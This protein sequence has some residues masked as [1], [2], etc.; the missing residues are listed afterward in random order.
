VVPGSLFI[1]RRGKQ[2]DGN[3][4]VPEAISSGAACVLS[5]VYDPSIS[6]VTQLLTDDVAAIE[7]RI[8]AAFWQHPSRDLHMIG[9]TG[10]SGKTTVSYIVHHLFA[11]FGIEAGLIGSVA[12]VSGVKSIAAS[13]TTP[14]A[15]TVQRLLRE[16]V[17]EGM[18]ASVMEVSSHGLSQRRVEGVEFDT[19]VFTNLSHEHLD[20]HMNMK[21]YAR[22]KRRL[23]T[24][25]QRTECKDPVIIVNNQDSWAEFI[26]EGSTGR[27]FTYAVEGEADLVASS[28]QLRNDGSSFTFRFQGEE[29]FVRSP[30]LGRFNV[31]NFLAA[32]GVFLSR[33]YALEEVA[34]GLATAAAPPG[35]LERVDNALDLRI[36]VDHAHKEEALCNVLR[37]IRETTRGKVIVVFGCGGNRDRAKRPLMAKAAA[38]L[39]GVAVVT[40]DNP[41]S[42]DPAAIIQEICSGFTTMDPIIRSCRRDAIYTAVELAA[43]D[44]CILIA[45]KGHEKQ[46]IFDG[47]TVDF[48]D[49][50][51]A[52]ECC[53]QLS[54]RRLCA[55][56]SC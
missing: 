5:D 55:T 30:L 27:F 36:Y 33:G 49:C 35:R 14:D 4:F 31:E 45:G 8:A 12:H 26:T 19:A 21:E 29:A 1:A 48:D 28:L 9:I 3:R 56:S 44:D 41:R 15:S 7:P 53:Q 52:K 23:F 13:H 50:L 17:C 16:F 54:N 25:L 40:S 24:S 42:E 47:S 37:T 22:A 51:V 39:A 10:T 34:R 11:Y 32:A 43:P 18:K 46:Q 6:H 2:F 38:K 20:Y